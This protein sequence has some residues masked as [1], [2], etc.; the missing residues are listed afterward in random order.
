MAPF[1]VQM[2]KVELSMEIIDPPHRLSIR[3]VQ[4]EQPQ[5]VEG[6]AQEKIEYAT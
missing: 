5:R 1:Q 4:P 6:H 3:F 2:D